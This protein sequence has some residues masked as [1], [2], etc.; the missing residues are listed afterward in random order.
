[1]VTSGPAVSALAVSPS[2]LAGTSAAREASG[3]LGFQVEL[4]VR[5]PEPVGGEQ[6]DR[7]AGD[8]E[9]NAG[10]HRQHVVAAGG[11]DRLGH[12]VRELV[13]RHGAG[14]AGMSGRV[15]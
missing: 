15:G 5:E 8:L 10:Q 11:R 2:T 13:G 1:M 9:A 7:R 14:G 6:R 3:L 12:G 4:A